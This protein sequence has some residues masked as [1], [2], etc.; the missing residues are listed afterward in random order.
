MVIVMRD[1]GAGGAE[2][3]VAVRAATRDAAVRDDVI[4]DAAARR[5]LSG[6]AAVQR[7]DLD[8]V[9]RL[10]AQ[11][12]QVQG[13]RLDVPVLPT[14]PAL[15]ELLPGGGLRPGAAYSL[16]S[17]ADEPGALSLL[18][19]LVAR[20]T[21]E[22]S[23]CGVVGMPE[24]GAEAAE[25]LGVDLGRLVLVPDPGT[26]WLAVAATIADVLPIVAVRP[27]GRAMGP[28]V[29]RLA[30]R[31]RERGAVLLVEGDWPQAEATL[32]VS[33]P[34]WTGLGDGFGYLAGRAL[35]VTATS[36]RWPVPRRSR[37]LLPAADGTVAPLPEHTSITALPRV[38]EQAAREGG[39]YDGPF[40]VREAG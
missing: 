23:W 9:T 36:R 30:A 28:E 22:G 6:V 13:L 8:A 40:E 11:M 7:G 18:L 38:D 2:G 14:H 12:A 27:G 15:T 29:S 5:G 3:S 26:R 34:Q 20:A 16:P 19:A 24:L 4:R 17:S 35:T 25:K 33:D 37:M 31:L 39:A 10:R 1:S 21:Q 32:R